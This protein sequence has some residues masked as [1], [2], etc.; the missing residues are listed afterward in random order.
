MKIITQVK[1]YLVPHLYSIRNYSD[2][3]LE[4]VNIRSDAQ[5]LLFDWHKMHSPTYH[6]GSIATPYIE[7]LAKIN[8]AKRKLHANYFS[9]AIGHP[10]EYLKESKTTGRK[11]AHTFPLSRKEFLKLSKERIS[12]AKN[13][14]EYVGVENLDYNEGG[15][16][17]ISAYELANGERITTPDFINE[18]ISKFKVNLLLDIG[19]LEVSAKRERLDPQNY[20]E[21]LPLKKI[22]EIHFHHATEV[23][24]V[25]RDTHQPPTDLEYYLL[26]RILSKANPEYITL[27][28]KCGIETYIKNLK[29]LKE[30]LPRKK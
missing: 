20:L 4:F 14:F 16:G 13:H 7:Y 9:M 26:D 8:F 30:M 17:E 25:L 21:M 28:F 1:D 5:E 19:H 2:G 11:V 29:I 3:P 27:E 12:L 24:G 6:L 23:G 10:C 18:F 15:P 22:Y